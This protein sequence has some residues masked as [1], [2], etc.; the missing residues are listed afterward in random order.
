MTE[1]AQKKTQNDD[2]G[3]LTGHFFQGNSDH[4]GDGPAEPP[5]IQPKQKHHEIVI[6]D[7]SEVLKK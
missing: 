1:G 7:K 3:L 4:I 6:K 5:I 2:F